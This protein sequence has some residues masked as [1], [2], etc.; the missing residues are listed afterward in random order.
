MHVNYPS[1]F[2]G[3]AVSYTLRVNMSVAAQRMRTDLNWSE[4]QK[5]Y[6]LVGIQHR[7]TLD[8]DGLDVNYYDSLPSIGD[9]WSAKF[10]LRSSPS[11]TVP[12]GC[13]V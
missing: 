9:I 2:S 4:V 13:S 10:P 11:T 1:L 6:V 7:D 3:L 12:N 5:G 8:S